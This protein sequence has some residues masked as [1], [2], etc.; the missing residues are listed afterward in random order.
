[1]EGHRLKSLAY[2]KG[3]D[4]ALLPGE[5]DL[6]SANEAKFS[7]DLPR[8]CGI[9]Q[10][11]AGAKGLSIAGSSGL[12]RLAV[13]PGTL[14]AS[15]PSREKVVS[16]PDVV[17]GKTLGALGPL[18][19]QRLLESLPLRSKP[20]GKRSSCS[21][22]PLP[23]SRSCF[24]ELG[25]ELDEEKTSWMLALCLS[26]NSL[27][28]DELFFEGPLNA[29]Q[30]DCINLLVKDVVR[31]CEI[32]ETVPELEWETF[33][34]VRSIDY[35]GEEVK[36]ARWFCWD[37]VGP[38]LPHDVGSVQLCDVC[39]LGS[40]HYVENFDSYLKEPSS[41][42]LTKPPK[43]MVSDDDW[44]GVCDGLVKAGVCIFLEE[45]E[46][47]HVGDAPLLNG[48][49]G[50]SKEE[51]TE[52]GVEIFRLIMNLIPLN[53]LCMPMT[54]D[55]GTLPSWALMNPMFLQPTEQLLVSSED[56][57]CFFYTLS[58]PS[59]WH[60]YMA[61]N[62]LVPDVVLPMS[63][64]GKR[65]YLASRVLPMGFLNS[66]SL[67]QHVHRNLAQWGGVRSN[68]GSNL[69]QNELR[70]DKPFSTGNPTWRIYLDNYDLLERVEASNV[71]ATQEQIPPG[72]LSLRQEYEVWG[73][74]RNV[75]KSVV[76]STKCE[77]QGA[78][79]DGVAG[80]AYPRESKLARYVGLAM[81]LCQ[82]TFGTQR[83]W[84]VTCG[85]LVYFCMF[86]RPLLGSL[87]RVWTHIE[88]FNASSK[89]SLRTPSDCL[90]EVYRFLGLLPLA[91]LDFRLDMHPSV[92]CSDASTKG[93]GACVSTGLTSLGGHVAAGKVRGQVP[94]CC[95]DMTVLSIGLFD[96]IGALR[97][98]LDCLNVNVC[99]HVSVETRGEAQ[100][101]VEANFPGSIIVGSVEEVDEEM[102]RTW[103]TMFTQCNVV[104]LGAG[105]PCQGV[106]GLNASRK[107]A[108]R[109]LRS[110]LFLHVPRIRDLVARA[111][112][113]CAVHSIMESVYS[114]DIEDRDVMSASFGCEPIL[115]DASGIIWCNRPRLY[116][117]SW[118]LSPMDCA[119]L[120]H[121][122][123]LWELVLSFRGDL[124]DCLKPGWKKV[125]PEA[126]FPTFTASRPRD[127]AGHR[128]AGVKQCSLA[129][130]ERWH[131]DQFRF[132]PYQYRE[133]HALTNSAGTLR[134]PDPEEREMLMGFPRGYTSN[135]L[136]KNLRHGPDYNDCRLTLLGNTW[137][138]QVIAVLVSQLFAC[139]GWISPMGP[140]EVVAACQAGNHTLAQGRLLRLP[141]SGLRTKCDCPEY[142][143][144]SKLGNLLSLKGEDILLTTPTSG[145]VKF[146]RLR[147]TVPS[148]LWKWRIISGWKWRNTADHINNLELRAILTTFK[149]RLEHQRQFNCRMIHLTDSLVCLHSLARGRTTSRKLRRVMSRL[150]ALVLASNVQPVWTY[151]HTDQNPADRPSRWGQ[152][153]KTKFRNGKRSST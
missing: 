28:G 148:R 93:G 54:G 150:N 68:D 56:V 95:P 144:A 133:C 112:P 91:R 129:E 113:W 24:S 123:D 63:L 14:S 30:K 44:A 41:W 126:C 2:E 66:V 128:P 135:C 102:V 118:E 115:C 121:N 6:P 17:S 16:R 92:T 94:E 53:N 21:L 98:A 90:V 13:S 96:G 10:P 52:S 130:L 152:R 97:V 82:G 85:G 32:P 36:V 45:S 72:V 109:D 103:S 75:K 3:L 124:S 15:D 84:Q 7:K 19:L 127:K 5:C 105:P 67:A 79:V 146:H 37:N 31:L 119:Q 107:G 88:S 111:F 136:A 61:F 64:R 101:V 69:A 145:M 114:M 25:L 108:L 57:K 81:K 9:G 48:L 149:W 131:D 139:L 4:T 142:E 110:S 143:L 38:A 23:T 151:V 59:A 117:L 125:N 100:R 138:I 49:F 35:R 27:W 134:L 39:T 76:R 89:P 116:W 74:P 47:F 46:V 120:Q 70:K 26:L 40:K 51:F 78:T 11:E 71:V 80:L 62:K 18:L 33:F 73:V 83:Q 34:K 43:V 60:K 1:M 22:F 106:S 8:C 29:G 55:I 42:T 65:T 87:N 147:A 58:V 12:A 20:T 122:G 132:P 153:V 104:L 137:C 50:V 99:G 140:R 77:M 141:M 86:R